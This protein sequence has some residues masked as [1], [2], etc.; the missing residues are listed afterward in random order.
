MEITVGEAIKEYAPFIQGKLL[1][2]GE[3]SEWLSVLESPLQGKLNSLELEELLEKVGLSDDEELHAELIRLEEGK[4]KPTPSLVRNG[5]DYQEKEIDWLVPNLLIKGSIHLLGGDP[6]AGKSYVTQWICALLSSGQEIFGRRYE[7]MKCFYISAEDSTETS[8]LKRIRVNG[9]LV[10]NMYF[11]NMQGIT[12]PSGIEHF[13]KALELHRPNFVVI[14][15]LNG[16]VDDDIDI[17][18]D[19]SIRKALQPFV[20]VAEYY[21]VAIL[22]NTH[23]NK[24]NA[25]SNPI[26]RFMGS[27]GSTA[28]SRVSLLLAKQENSDE[29]ILSVVKT[30][31]GQEVNYALKWNWENGVVQN[32]GLTEL[33]ANEIGS[34][35]TD[36]E[37]CAEEILEY[38]QE[39]SNGKSSSAELDSR[40]KNDYSS[41][42]IKRARKKLGKKIYAKKES[43]K[44][45]V[46]LA[47]TVEP[48]EPLHKQKGVSNV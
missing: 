11:L 31:E 33:K 41:S 37:L 3:N 14:D 36:V 46:Y 18:K 48:L 2:L 35:Q 20:Q 16:F 10:E 6:S 30:N 5:I 25:N 23:L 8:T 12:F 21:E 42:T 17:Y 44:W 13:Q 1:L 47:E 27:I 19:S 22:F 15:P 28:V 26:Y 9:G 40:F 32:L 4:K 34:E 24:G 29:R 38:L 39:L 43:N 7:P 45:Y